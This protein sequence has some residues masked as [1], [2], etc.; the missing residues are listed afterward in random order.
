MLEDCQLDLSRALFNS[1]CQD[2]FWKLFENIYK[3]IDKNPSEN[4]GGLCGWRGDYV[5]GGE[6]GEPE[7]G[8]DCHERGGQ[9]GGRRICAIWRGA[10]GGTLWGTVSRELSY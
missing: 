10:R 8:R 1:N 9:R 7:Y 4:I 2:D 6:Y 3:T 5:H